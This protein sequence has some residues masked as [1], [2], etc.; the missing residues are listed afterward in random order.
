[1]TEVQ[2]SAD[3]PLRARRLPVQHFGPWCEPVQLAGNLSPESLR[4]LDGP[5]IQRLVSRH[6][7]HMRLGREIRGWGKYSGLIQGGAEMLVF[8]R[9]G[10]AFRCP[11][12]GDSRT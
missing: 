2:L 9:L 5:P 1:V 6:A 3:K 7:A 11:P 12:R 10:H 8:C 4:L